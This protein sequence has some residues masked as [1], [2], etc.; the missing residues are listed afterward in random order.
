MTKIITKQ[1]SRARRQ[2]R[3][4]SRI[5]GNAERPRLA[6]FR[7]NKYISAQLIDDAA[8]Q[9]IASARLPRREATAAGVAIAKAALAKN[10]KAAV[11]DRAGYLYAGRVKAV[12]EGARAAGLQI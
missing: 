6:V 11:F 12:A 4:R 8:G 5:A 1:L 2:R 10:I 3:I 7:S 9:T